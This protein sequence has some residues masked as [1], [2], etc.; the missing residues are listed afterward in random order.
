[1][2]ANTQLS[3]RTENIATHLVNASFR[4]HKCIGPGLLESVYET[5][6]IYELEK[7]GFSVKSQLT[8]PFFT[9]TKIWI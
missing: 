7:S 6:L 3:D 8:I 9:I 2:K 5:C 4:V 1:M